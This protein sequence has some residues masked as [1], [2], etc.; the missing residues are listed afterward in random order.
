[1]D[2]VTNKII[3]GIFGRLW[4]NSKKMANIKSFELKATMNYEAVKINGELC[5]QNRYLGYA[6]SG[7][8]VLHKTDTYTAS[9]IGKGIRS[10]SLPDI[11]FVGAISDP[12]SV[13]SERIEV[14]N[15]TF[16]EVTLMHFVNGE[17][18]EESIPFKAGGYR[19]IDKI[20]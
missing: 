14:Y 3:R 8:M 5:E 13:G 4:I 15:V 2:N 9:L 16:D 7:T 1:M 10:G 19:F 6:L 20:E 11:K 17:I 18:G 12:D